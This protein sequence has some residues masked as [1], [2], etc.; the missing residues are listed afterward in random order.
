MLVVERNLAS[1]GQ[2]TTNNSDRTAGET[3]SPLD[4]H[5]SSSDRFQLKPTQKQNIIVRKWKHLGLSQDFFD[6][7]FCPKLAGTSR[8]SKGSKLF[9]RPPQRA[10]QIKYILALSSSTY[11]HAGAPACDTIN[12]FKRPTSGPTIETS[13]C[14]GRVRTPLQTHA[15]LLKNTSNTSL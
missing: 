13:I 10:S 4:N 9:C 3:L 12:L 7:S 14:L 6:L 2:R 15:G 8:E 11:S 5:M 1:S